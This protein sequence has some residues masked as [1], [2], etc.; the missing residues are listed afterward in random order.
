[1]ELHHDLT[2]AQH[3]LSA[4]NQKQLVVQLGPK[5]QVVQVTI[6]P[7]EL[8]LCVEQLAH[9][10]VAAVASAMA[11]NTFFMVSP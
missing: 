6:R 1:V 9:T 8:M 10:A 11:A 5:Q 2:P 7:P 3:P 4:K